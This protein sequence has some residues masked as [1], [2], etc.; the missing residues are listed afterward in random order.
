M[1]PEV[2]LGGLGGPSHD[3]PVS[4]PFYRGPPVPPV[5]TVY[6]KFEEFRG[7]LQGRDFQ[8]LLFPP[9]LLGLR[10]SPTGER[11]PGTT[12]SPEQ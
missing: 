1:R 12:P 2:R 11:V 3:H 10:P 6:E 5:G 4:T 8:I 9:P 7:R